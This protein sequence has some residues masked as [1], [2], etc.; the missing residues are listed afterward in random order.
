MSAPPILSF[1]RVSLSF[2]ET[3]AL[4]DVSFSVAAGESLIILGAAGSGKTTLLKMALGLLQPDSGRIAVFGNDVTRAEEQQ[5]YEVR[6]HIGVLFQEGGLFDSLTIEDNVAYPL[7]NP[8]LFHV[9]EDEILKRVQQS[10]DFVELGHTLA[11]FPSELSGGMRR[12]VGIARAIVT[13]PALLLYDSP[14][15]G[16][17]PI[18]A[19]NIISLIV[20][21]RD[22]RNAATVMATHR[23]QDGEIM[24][25]YRWDPGA[26]RL[27]VARNGNG[28][29]NSTRYLVLREGEI[30]FAG[31]PEELAASKDPYTVRFVRQ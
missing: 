8:R 26:Q 11:K 31:S 16:L 18:T 21:G 9:P 4:R 29:R 12:R 15:A 24:A 22:V 28:L 6:S 13:Q 19:N 25:G 3:P 5:W 2:D 1:E 14:T 23:A 20:K 10:L 17:D 7:R 30:V 27:A